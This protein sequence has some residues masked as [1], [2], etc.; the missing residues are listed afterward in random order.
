[1]TRTFCPAWMR[2]ARRPWRAASPETATTAACSKL[3]LAGLRASL[4]SRAAAYSANEP[5]AMPNTWSPARNLVTSAP[6]AATAPATSSPGTGFFGP[7]NPK[8]S[9][10]IR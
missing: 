3:S 6:A 10:R 2:P 5:R 4:S 1:M 7:R 9:S 8:P